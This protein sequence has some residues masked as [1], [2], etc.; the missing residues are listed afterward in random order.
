MLILTAGAGRTGVRWSNGLKKQVEFTP[1]RESDIIRITA[2]SPSPEEAAAIA[3]SYATLYSE[4]NLEASRA[5]S[6]A[7]REFLEAQATAKQ[8]SLDSIEQSLQKY[9]KT[10]GVVSLDASANKLVEQLAE[11]ES[12][13]DASEL[14]IATKSQMLAGYKQELATQEPNAL[15]AINASDDSYIKLLQEQLAQL[16]V[17]RDV[18]IAQNPELT[19]DRAYS[20]KLKEL[21]NQIASLKANLQ[22]RTKDYVAAVLPSGNPNA[23]GQAPFVGT[24][25]EKIIENRDRALR[26]SRPV[27]IS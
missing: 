1:I 6:K 15:R 26:A 19:S 22:Q 17:Q 10:A 5:R 23:E 25:K 9:M 3:N 14:E 27:G 2:R 11:I 12:N 16:E 20:A 13:R 21:E 18:I 4:R 7:M 24:L 8:R